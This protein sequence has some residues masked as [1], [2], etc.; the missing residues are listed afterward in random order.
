MLANHQWATDV[1]GALTVIVI[2]EYQRL[3]PKVVNSQLQPGAQDRF[4]W[5]W[6]AGGLL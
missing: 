6:T 4:V 1:T 5:K 3:W 2:T